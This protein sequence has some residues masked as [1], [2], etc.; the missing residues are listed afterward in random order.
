[1]K[2]IV[3]EAISVEGK[4]VEPGTEIEL[5][6]VEYLRASKSGAVEPVEVYEAREGAKR[7]ATKA[8][9]EADSVAAR[10]VAEAESKAKDA[11]DKI[12]AE[13]EAQVEGGRGARARAAK[14]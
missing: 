3:I 7:A 8:K 11:A 1:M 12:R 10:V 4:R 13:A 9:A 2:C 14:G 6:P 5:S